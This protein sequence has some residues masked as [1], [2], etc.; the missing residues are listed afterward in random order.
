LFPS[1]Q[2]S[3]GGCGKGTTAPANTVTVRGGKTLR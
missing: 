2:L 3:L 1:I